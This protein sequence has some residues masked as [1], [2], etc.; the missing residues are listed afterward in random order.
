MNEKNKNTAILKELQDIPRGSRILQI[1][2]PVAWLIYVELSPVHCYYI[3]VDKK[4]KGK[5]KT[6]YT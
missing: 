4:Q 1:S 3:T 6:F 2:T 5:G